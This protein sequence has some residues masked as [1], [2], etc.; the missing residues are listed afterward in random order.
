MTERAAVWLV[1]FELGGRVERYATR[2]VVPVT[3]A[4]VPVVFREGLAPVAFD[5]AA[6]LGGGE[7]S[8]A[9]AISADWLQS[10]GRGGWAKLNAAFHLLEG[11][12][13]VLLRWTPGTPFESA[14][15]MLRGVAEEVEFGG[16]SEDLVFTLKRSLF[17]NSRPILSPFAKVDASTWVR[18]IAAGIV[19]D[20]K[21]VGAQ[22]P[23]IYGYP[24]DSRITAAAPYGIPVAASPAVTGQI[25]AQAFS[26]FVIADGPV[27]AIEVRVFDYSE[28]P[29]IKEDLIVQ[30]VADNLGRMIPI[31]DFSAAVALVAT[32]GHAYHVGWGQAVNRGGGRLRTDGRGGV[33][34][35]LGEVVADLM[36]GTRADI[37]EID[38]RLD[39]WLIDTWINEPDL[40]PWDW[41]SRELAPIC[42]FRLVE[43]RLG[44]ALRLFDWE[45]KPIDCVRRFNV[46]RGELDRVSGLKNRPSSS[47]VNQAIVE[48]KR[49]RVSSFTAR[50]TLGSAPIVGDESRSAGS[51][52]AG[53]SVQR[54]ARPSIGDDGI[55]TKVYQSSAIW[56]PATAAL[57]ARY[58][59]AELAL[60]PVDVV[61]RGRPG[62]E[63]E[64]D[65]CD[66]ILITDSEVGIFGRVLLV[67]RITP[68]P[69]DTI[70]AGVLLDDPTTRARTAL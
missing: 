18:T 26:Q 17:A 43:G 2:A 48:Y 28:N 65:P 6:D 61:Y 12:A 50:Y 45:A 24:G 21:Y 25:R 5:L 37:R 59:I 31:V 27:E 36:A 68:G 49:D 44:L 20:E 67:D 62:L 69:T 1:E 22:Y 7:I 15:V 8:T 63:N 51:Y 41:I 34:R 19:I 58:K 53:L 64:I 54:M 33:I 29:P 38:S 4:G 30:T 39:Q 60:A 23:R 32:P 57:V 10:I 13:G 66:P 70:I 42:P 35:G 47:V 40:A 56:E 14:R 11:G 16:P 3:L 55:R 46:D 52:R 9:I